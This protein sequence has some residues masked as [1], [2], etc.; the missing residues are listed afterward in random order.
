[1]GDS[2]H[3]GTES[4]RIWVTRYTLVNL[5]ET[6]LFTSFFPYKYLSPVKLCMAYTLYCVV[7][8]TCWLAV[9]LYG[10]VE[11]ALHTSLKPEE[12]LICTEA[13]FK[14][15]RPSNHHRGR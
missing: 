6:S 1:M 11:K 5:Y 14:T 12:A 4:P 9:A 13:K 10:V 2:A 3:A 7:E 15:S 8:K